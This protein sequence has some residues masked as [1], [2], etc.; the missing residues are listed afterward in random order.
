M[1]QVLYTLLTI[2]LIAG[3]VLLWL[4]VTSEL[5]CLIRRVP[6]R[7]RETGAQPP[8]L[9]FLVPAH[10]EE[11]NIGA[12]AASLLGLEYPSDRRR[13]IVVADNCSDRT[14][15]LAR[16]A[17]AECLERADLALPGKPRALAWALS[18]VSLPDY[19]SVVI[20][21]ADTV[22]D[23]GF[24]RALAD[25]G[26]LGEI[27]AQANILAANERENWL[28]RLGGVLNR[29]RYQVTYPIK[30]RAGLNIPLT[31]NG[32]ALG[33]RVI[34]RL[35]WTAFSIAE[36]S[37]L[38]AQY[39]IAGVPILHAAA[40]TVRSGE[41]SSLGAGATQ[42]R[43][44]LAGRLIILRERWREVLRSGAVDWHQKVDLLVELALASPVLHLL[45]ALG[46]GGLGLALYP[47]A[48][49]WVIVAAALGSLSAIVAT[50]LVVLW[51]H[52]EPGPTLLAF[53]RLPL[54]AVWRA[55]LFVRTLLTLRDRRWVRSP[56]QRPA[57]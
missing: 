41:P 7:R 52:E 40:A 55:A 13:V 31:G 56:R 35:G 45:L 43:R 37:E 28:T 10:D 36:D 57:A 46:F 26:P 24:A 3:L 30:A 34:E 17:G 2:L 29:C 23:P 53:L 6:L 49:G 5:L 25:L 47:G 39:T 54:Y 19:D 48:V 12:T 11:L 1:L 38:Y 32:M 33:A 21:D 9:L 18:Q 14:A 20:V 8:S 22:A 50:T 4:P 27:A 51:R 16:A 42:R 15:E 44:W